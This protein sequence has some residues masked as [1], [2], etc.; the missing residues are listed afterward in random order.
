MIWAT[1]TQG[2]SAQVGHWSRW[3]MRMSLY[4]WAPNAVFGLVCS[5]GN[6]R[7]SRCYLRHLALLTYL[8][9][10]L[11]DQPT[12]ITRHPGKNPTAFEMPPASSLTLHPNFSASWTLVLQTVLSSSSTHTWQ[13]PLKTATPMHAVQH[14]FLPSWICAA[15][16]GTCGCK[17]TP[18]FLILVPS[19]EGTARTVVL[20]HS[21]C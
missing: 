14:P 2:G 15:R 8:P 18:L 7:T 5:M 20:L 11:E 19:R 3:S 17:T 12:E 1:G 6:P 10:D 4:C 16:N 21:T 9:A 13:Q